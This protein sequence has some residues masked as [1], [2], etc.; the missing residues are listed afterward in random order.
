[1]ERITEIRRVGSLALGWLVVLG[2]VVLLAG[3]SSLPSAGAQHSAPS[4]PKDFPSAIPLYQG[5]IVSSATEGPKR[6]RIWEVV[7]QLP[8]PQAMG[9]IKKQLADAGLKPAVIGQSNHAGESILGSTTTD[10]VEIVLAKH[11]DAWEATYIVTA[12]AQ[13]S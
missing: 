10:T 4:V 6:D 2:S 9:T 7:I 1:M 5:Q 11:A 3:C 13:Y 8:S 12:A